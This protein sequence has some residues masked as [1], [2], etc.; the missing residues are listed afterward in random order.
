MTTFG[1]VIDVPE[2]GRGSL[3]AARSLLGDPEGLTIPPHITL[4]APLTIDP[5][6]MSDVVAHVVGAAEQTE[7]FFVHL[8]GT[9]TFRPVSPVVFVALSEGISRCEELERRIRT[10]PLAIDLRFPYHPH[11]TVAQELPDDVLDRAFHQLA[12][13]DF[14]FRVERLSLY[15]LDD[16]GWVPARQIALGRQLPA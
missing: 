12:D 9:A 7:P 11:V 3:Q 16:N 10:G 4:V 6:E 2:P 13:Y 8:R 14:R 1:L 15:E 5:T